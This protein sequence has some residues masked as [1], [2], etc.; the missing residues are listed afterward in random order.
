MRIIVGVLT[1][2]LLLSPPL[3]TAQVPGSASAPRSGGV[4]RR[5]LANN[6]ATLDPAISDTYGF[7]VTQQIFDGLVQ[8]DGG[9]TII[10]AIAS[11]WKASRNGLHWVFYL[12]TGV[13]FHHGREVVADDV[14]YSFTRLLDPRLNSKASEYLMNI[15][16]AKEYFEGQARSIQGI[17]AVDRH[18]VEITLTEASAP[19][20]TYLAIGYVKIVP[21]EA[22]EDRSVPFGTRPIGTGPFK[23]V[24]WK[25]DEEIV[26]E[27]HGSYY[28]GSP[29]LDRLVYKIYPGHRADEMLA[30]FEAG[31]L[32][33]TVI[34]AAAWRQA[35]ETKRFRLVQRPTLG[36]R[37]FG[38]TTTHPPLDNPAVRKALNFAID[39]EA[40]VRDILQGRFQPGRGFLPPGTYG[41]D[42]QYRPYPFDPQKARALLAAAGH[43]GG[44]GIPPLQVWSSVKSEGIEREHEAIRRYLLDVGVQIEYHYNTNWPA[45]NAQVQEGKLP[46]FRYGWSADVPEPEYFLHRIFHSQSRTN[47]TRYANPRV[48]RLLDRA[49]QEADP[50]K[51]AEVYREAERLIMDD[52][53]VIPLNYVSYDRLFQPYVQS[54][55]VSALGDPYIPMRKIWL[56]Q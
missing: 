3:A 9:L 25:K 34:P 38:L 36:V 4:Y 31:N 48:D 39:K 33:D 22:V 24:H 41:S 44:K 18:T 14:V 19:F 56:A 8:Y 13:R 53:P 26:L 54:I 45:F 7:T 43:P 35:Q 11:S 17:R 28:G 20:V 47:F 1:L 50:V 2:L 30:A 5:P 12:K 40:L 42:P 37:F 32:E 23:F 27:R 46:I 6:P 55:E 29:F 49:R 15:R 10:P 52:A 16:G 51:R 21:R